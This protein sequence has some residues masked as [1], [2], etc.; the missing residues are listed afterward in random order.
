[1]SIN[2]KGRT[3]WH[4]AT[5]KTPKST[6]NF[7]GPAAYIKG[8]I[9]ALALWGWW[10]IGLADRLTHR[11]EGC[12]MLDALSNFHDVV[13]ALVCTHGHRLPSNRVNQGGTGHG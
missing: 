3:G 11:G 7:T 1:M 12:T 13:T 8:L 4:Q 9:I 6:R 10:S 5:P 2:K